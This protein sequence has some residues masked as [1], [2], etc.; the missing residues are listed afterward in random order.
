MDIKI[1]HHNIGG[2]RE[3]HLY[4]ENRMILI[5]HLTDM[6]EHIAIS[7]GF[8]EYVSIDNNIR[9]CLKDIPG[10]IDLDGYF[11]I[12][13]IL[14]VEHATHYKKPYCLVQ[15][16]QSEASTLWELGE[17]EQVTLEEVGEM[18]C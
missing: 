1:F 7:C 18:A 2:R 14:S 5:T 11:N 16:K 15:T 9:I 6:P 4:N 13:H 12:L 17:R 3:G 10:R 8:M